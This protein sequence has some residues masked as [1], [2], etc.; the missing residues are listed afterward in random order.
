MTINAQS[1]LFQLTVN[2][3]ASDTNKLLSSLE[4]PLNINGKAGVDSNVDFS[5]LLND[6]AGFVDDDT[7][8]EAEFDFDTS[9]IELKITLDEHSEQNINAAL[10][11]KGFPLNPDITQ[12]LIKVND[13]GVVNDE[14][15]SNSNMMPEE[16]LQLK[17]ELTPL[18][19][20]YRE[21]YGLCPR[22]SS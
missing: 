16:L 14:L 13:K 18:V 15:L 1:N 4:K 19:D 3:P 22:E 20:K 6:I 11:G 17:I 7:N 21:I 10:E 12:S 8:V 9:K 5:E 2:S